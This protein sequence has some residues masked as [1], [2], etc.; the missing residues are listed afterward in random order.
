[1]TAAKKRDFPRGGRREHQRAR[2]RRTLV[3]CGGVTEREYFELARAELHASA[4]K[5]C[6]VGRDPLGIVRYADK[7][8]SEAERRDEAFAEVWAVTDVDDF[9]N[10][11]EAQ[12]LARKLGI[13]LA[14]SNPCFEV[15]LIDHVCV[16]GELLGHAL[17]RGEGTRLRACQ[18]QYRTANVAR[19]GKAHPS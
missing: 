14:I 4:T 2:A 16:P 8:K 15:W 18:R 11:A 12:T 5:V 17:M 9:K 13:H 6:A 19:E 7:L 3:V 1:M 10:L